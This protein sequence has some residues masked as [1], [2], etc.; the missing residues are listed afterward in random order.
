M[1]LLSFG[2][3]RQMARQHMREVVPCASLGAGWLK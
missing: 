1:E 3:I 2:D